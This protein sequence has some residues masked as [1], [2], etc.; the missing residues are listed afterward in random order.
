MSLV[1][2]DSKIDSA[3]RRGLA[4]PPAGGKSARKMADK[5]WATLGVELE[6]NSKDKKGK[7]STG[8]IN[9]SYLFLCC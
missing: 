9:G 8:K 3:K 6:G 7:V 5:R 2:R 4:N 1:A